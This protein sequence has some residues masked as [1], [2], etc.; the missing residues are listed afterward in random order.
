ML[1]AHRLLALWIGT[2]VLAAT[3]AADD[4]GWIDV[5]RME[6]GSGNEVSR[7]GLQCRIPLAKD[8]TSLYAPEATVVLEPRTVAVA[9]DEKGPGISERLALELLPTPLESPSEAGRSLGH[10]NVVISVPL[11]EAM[12]LRTGVRVDYDSSPGSGSF[13]AEA[14][15]TVG[16]GFEF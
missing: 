9:R 8:E 10:G 2:L 6:P 7:R 1:S 4:T 12:E 13:N 15:P 16:V 14:I 5:A 11:G 3:A